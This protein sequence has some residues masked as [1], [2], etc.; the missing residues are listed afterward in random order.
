MML[1]SSRK[2]FLNLIQFVVDDEAKRQK[3]I[4]FRDPS[5]SIFLNFSNGFQ[6]GHLFPGLDLPP[7]F[8]GRLVDFRTRVR[9]RVVIACV[10]LVMKFVNSRPEWM[11]A[12]Q[13]RQGEA[14]KIVTLF[15]R[16]S[17][18]GHPRDV[19]GIAWRV[20]PID[21]LHRNGAFS[22]WLAPKGL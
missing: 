16:E 21:S 22:P 19:A 6:S 15:R 1:V 17:A 12:R 14:K 2:R 4:A 18:D 20:H 8:D 13:H 11:P 9:T 3:I 10:P 7:D 5:A